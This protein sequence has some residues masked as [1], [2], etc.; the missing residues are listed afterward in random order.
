MYYSNLASGYGLLRDRIPLEH[1]QATLQP[2]SLAAELCAADDDFGRRR[3]MI[4][5]VLEI[6]PDPPKFRFELRQSAKNGSPS[7]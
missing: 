1:F 6:D 4:S 5:Q 3:V 2:R 7:L